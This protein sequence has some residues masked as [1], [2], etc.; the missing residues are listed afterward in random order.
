MI[1]LFEFYPKNANYW[2]RSSITGILCYSVK[3]LSIIN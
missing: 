1:A 2:M 3:T